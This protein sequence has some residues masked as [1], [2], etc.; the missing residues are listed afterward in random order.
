MFFGKIYPVEKREVYRCGKIDLEKLKKSLDNLGI[1]S[2]LRVVTLQRKNRAYFREVEKLCDEKGIGYYSQSLTH[3]TVPTKDKIASILEV[4]RTAKY[5]ILIMCHRGA[6]R[7][8]L[9]SAFYKM[10]KRR[11]EKEALSQL[12]FHPYGHFW[13]MHWRYHLFLKRLYKEFKGDLEKYLESD[14][15]YSESLWG[16]YRGRTF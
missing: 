8:G 7:S 16:K 12:S 4:F 13:F 9:T 6:D 11:S 5:P 15:D 3:N 10:Y 14:V 2:I 1:K